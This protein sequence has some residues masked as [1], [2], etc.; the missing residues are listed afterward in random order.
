MRRRTL[1]EHAQAPRT[2]TNLVFYAVAVLRGQIQNKTPSHMF[3]AQYI[4]CL[5]KNANKSRPHTHI[6]KQHTPQLSSAARRTRAAC[7]R[8]PACFKDD[9]ATVCAHTRTHRYTH[10]GKGRANAHSSRHTAAT[11]AAAAG[12]AL[13]IIFSLWPSR[14]GRR[15]MDTRGPRARVPM[16]QESAPANGRRWMGGGWQYQQ[17]QQQHGCAGRRGSHRTVKNDSPN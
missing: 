3:C 10:T 14:Y 2:N 15:R 9:W 13:K 17:G 8:V 6:E 7:I 11:T 5:H 12:W 1:D 16:E 4:H